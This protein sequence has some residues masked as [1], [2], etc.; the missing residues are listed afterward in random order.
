MKK[1]GLGLFVVILLAIG[2]CEKT[3]AKPG[4]GNGIPGSSPRTNVPAHL[5]GNWMYGYFSMTEYW[6]QNPSTYLGNGFEMAIA[7]TFQ[8]NGVYTQY[9][10]SKSVVL[11][12]STYHQSVTKGTVEVDLAGNVIKTHPVSSHYKRTKNGKTEEDRDMRPEEI[13]SVTQYTFTTGKEPGGTNALYLTLAGTTS[14]Y[15]FLQK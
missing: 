7:F 2:G 14:P 9:F 8:P 13:S 4:S 5:Q 3:N 12:V 15:T 11:G 6:S 1:V 10:T